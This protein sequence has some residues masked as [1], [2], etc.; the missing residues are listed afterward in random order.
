M[1][2]KEKEPRVDGLGPRERKQIHSAVRLVWSRSH[3]RRLAI[4]RATDAQGFTRCEVCRKRS[5]KVHVDHPDPVGAVDGPDYIKK[6]FQPSRFY[7]V[8]CPPCHRLK[9]KEDR[10]KDDLI[11][12]GIF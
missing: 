11:K 12:M 1:A 2:K 8:L 6:M 9:T 5:P 7:K 3:A 4:L 10:D